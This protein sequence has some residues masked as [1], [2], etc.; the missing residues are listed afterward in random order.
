MGYRFELEGAASPLRWPLARRNRA[1]S[2]NAGSA[3]MRADITITWYLRVKSS[4]LD[5]QFEFGLEALLA[6]LEE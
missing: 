2:I 3:V 1:P 4:D 6:G 5:Q